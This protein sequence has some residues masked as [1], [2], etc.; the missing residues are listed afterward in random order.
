MDVP[1]AWGQPFQRL[2]SPRNVSA[3]RG[4]H[5]LRSAAI[6]AQVQ[7]WV[8]RPVPGGSVSVGISTPV[9]PLTVNLVTPSE[10]RLCRPGWEQRRF[11]ADDIAAQIAATAARNGNNPVISSPYPL[12]SGPSPKLTRREC[13]LSRQAADRLTLLLS[14]GTTMNFGRCLWSTKT[15]VA[16]RRSGSHAPVG[17]GMTLQPKP[18]SYRTGEGRRLR[19]YQDRDDRNGSASQGNLGAMGVGRPSEDWRKP[20]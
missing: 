18:H 12:P 10:G 2:A 4:R 13:L 17:R 5:D 20:A 3:L 16:I 6:V 15:S 11:H 1:K 9:V 14:N 7:R 8:V 19:G